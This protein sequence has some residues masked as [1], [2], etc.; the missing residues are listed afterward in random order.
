MNLADYEAYLRRVLPN[1]VQNAL[2]VAIGNEF[3]PIETHLQRRMMEIIQDA[4][5]QA[6]SSFRNMQ[7]SEPEVGSPARQ[8]RNQVSAMENDQSTTI[9]TFFQPPPPTTHPISFTNLSELRAQQ[10]KK[11]HNTSDSG[12][13]SNPPLSSSSH[14]N[15]L[16]AFFSDTDD[17]MSL[18]FNVPMDSLLFDAAQYLNFEETELAP[19]NDDF[20]PTQLQAMTEEQFD[21]EPR[22][23]YFNHTEMTSFED[24]AVQDLGETQGAQ[25][26]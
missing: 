3:Q 25:A 17:Q 9:E 16:D 18:H 11:K 22:S 6:F 13:A 12:Y 19:S 21:A 4:Q 24:F 7:R 10:S 15:S 23:S 5:N 1:L 8:D 14:H 2:E 26:D 20:V